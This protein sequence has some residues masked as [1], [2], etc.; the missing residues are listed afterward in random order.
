VWLTRDSLRL[1]SG[2]GK[3][4]EALCHEGVDSGP[5]IATTALKLSFHE[6]S[7]GDH[8]IVVMLAANDHT[9]LGPQ[10]TL[11]IKIP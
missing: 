10:Q 6:L 3:Y 7:S 9:P 5:V 1:M 2:V 4:K 11:E 8:K